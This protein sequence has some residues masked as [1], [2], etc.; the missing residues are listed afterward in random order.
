MARDRS[1]PGRDRSALASLRDARPFIRPQPAVSALR[2]STAGY[3]LGSLPA[4]FGAANLSGQRADESFS[5]SKERFAQP[6][7]SLAARAGPV[8]PFP[9]NRRRNVARA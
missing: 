6:R 2:A 1:D 8:P 5:D 4:S 9:N 7:Q 3:R